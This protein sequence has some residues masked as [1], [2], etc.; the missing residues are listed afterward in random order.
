[1]TSQ[2]D[3]RVAVLV[4]VLSVKAQ[5]EE[6]I[7]KPLS[8]DEEYQVPI[9]LRHEESAEFPPDDCGKNRRLVLRP[10]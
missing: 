6:V 10:C 1:M 9:G 7:S 5:V 4:A 8:R 3:P 2:N